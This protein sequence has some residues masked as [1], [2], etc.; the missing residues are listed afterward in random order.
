[1]PP[2]PKHARRWLQFSIRD[3]LWF[4]ALVACLLFAWNLNRAWVQSE[5]QWRSAS[6][7]QMIRIEGDAA[8]RANKAE[9]I[10]AERVLKA[11]QIA[12]DWQA[13]YEGKFGKGRFVIESPDDEKSEN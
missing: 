12:R 11:E 13:L 3:L 8:A 6:H 10:A 2:A 4:A 9:L 7:E 5:K 1:M